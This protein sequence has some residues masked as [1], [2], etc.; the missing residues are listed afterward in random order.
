[1][2]ESYFKMKVNEGTYFKEKIKPT[3]ILKAGK[4]TPKESKVNFTPKEKVMYSCG[5]LFQM[6]SVFFKIKD[7]NDS[8]SYYP[9][10]L[11]VQCVCERFIN[12]IIFHPD[13]EF[14]DT[15]PE[16]ESESE[17]EINKSTVLDE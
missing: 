15:E 5:I 11:L 2:G 9:Q 6:Q 13:L 4:V 3:L 16:S 1:M 12:K 10:L 7:K 14:T 17:E 8:I